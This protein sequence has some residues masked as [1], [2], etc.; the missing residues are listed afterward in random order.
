MKVRVKVWLEHKGEQVF[1]SGK[2]DIL[3]AVE[4]TGSLNAAA[5]QLGMSYR[6]VWAAI[7]AAEERLGRPL[8]RKQRGGRKGGGATLTNYA[9][10]LVAQFEALEKDIKDGMNH[11][12]A[13]QL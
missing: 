8:L 5:A 12:S 2:A 9:R 13:N 7:R 3:H 1:G 6:H 11:R 10:K 4:E